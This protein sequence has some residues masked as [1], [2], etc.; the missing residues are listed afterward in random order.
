MMFYFQRGPVK[1]GVKKMEPENY[2][3]TGG[4]GCIG[5]WVVRSLVQQGFPVVVLDYDGDHHRLELI[6]NADQL[7]QVNFVTGDV[8]D[9]ELLCS[10]FSDYRIRRVIH[11]AALQLPFCKANP[12]LGALVNVVGTINI[13][14]AARRMGLRHVVYASSAAVYG[15]KECYPARPIKH[16]APLIPG[17]HYG[18]YKQANELGAKIYWQEQS[19]SSIGLRPHVVYGAG[20]DQGMTSTPTKAMLAAAAGRAYTISFGGRYCF[21]Y[22]G[23]VAATFIRA[24]QVHFDG[25]EVFN[26]GGP[27]SS[28]LDI[29]K[30]IEACEPS[31]TGKI[32]YDAVALPFPEEYDNS[33][34]TQILGELEPTRLEDGVEET[35]TIFK[36]ALKDGKISEPQVDSIL[37]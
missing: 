6:M 14:E 29:I 33:Y 28:T 11:L 15:P 32:E 5:A 37:A 36:D 9:L 16:G 13:F 27:A 8:R 10:I 30:A 7:S 34:L 20:R 12:S 18:I 19:I 26:I 35:I 21:Q 23:D 1:I 17:S 24:S 4:T 2:L 3:V 22:G 25:A 31:M